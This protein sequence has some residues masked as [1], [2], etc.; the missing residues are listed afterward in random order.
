ME[1][2]PHASKFINAIPLAGHQETFALEHIV[3]LS[4]EGQDGKLAGFIVLAT[5]QGNSIEFRRILVD[6]NQRGIG[7]MAITLMEHYCQKNMG[8]TRIWLDVYDDNEIGQH[9]YDK[10]QYRRFK[11]ERRGERLLHFYDKS[12]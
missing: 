3:Y 9:I 1:R 11:S 4:I 2:Q 5:E 7:Q 12:L 8:T 6:E 10:L